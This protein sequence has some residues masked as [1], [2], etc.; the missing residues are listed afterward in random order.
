MLLALLPFGPVTWTLYVP[1][2]ELAGVVAV[3]CVELFT[4]KDV[5]ATEATLTAVAPVKPVPVMVM[6]VPPLTG[7]L[8]GLTPV[9]VGAAVDPYVNCEANVTTLKP[10][11]VVT[12]TFT[13][14]VPK[15]RGTIAVI[16][17]SLSTVKFAEIPPKVTTVAP[18]K[19][20]PVMIT[21]VPATPVAGLMLVTVGTPEA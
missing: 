13:M 20:V 8:E 2:A 16:W 19:P 10:T 3:I 5:T 9:T 1:G 15:P 4:V 21:M 18:V 7:P 12:T 11:G 14:P 6:T 17:V